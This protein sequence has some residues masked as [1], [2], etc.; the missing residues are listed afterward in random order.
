MKRI[1]ALFAFAALLLGSGCSE[2]KE[3]YS[4]TIR[5]VTEDGIPVQNCDLRID[6]PI[7]N[8]SKFELYLVTDLGG[9][10]TFNY[11]HKAFFDV[12]ATKGFGWIGCGYVEL[13][14]GEDAF[15]EVTIYRFN[16]R[17]NGCP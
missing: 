16:A 8:D 14:N 1:V 2:E 7:D 9:F 17:F 4:A 13:V 3:R 5:V 6:T 12:T 15:T 10:A 11:P